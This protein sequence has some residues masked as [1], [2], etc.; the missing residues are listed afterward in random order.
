[1]ASMGYTPNQESC[2]SSKTTLA[3]VADPSN[4]QSQ[5]RL[6]TYSKQCTKFTRSVRR[7]FEHNILSDSSGS[8]LA[9]Y[10]R[11]H[12]QSVSPLKH[13]GQHSPATSDASKCMIM[14]RHY[15]SIFRPSVSPPIPQSYPLP[16]LTSPPAITTELISTYLELI[17][18]KRSSV[19]HVNGLLLRLIEGD[20][21]VPYL[22]DLIEKSFFDCFI[23]HQWK[24]SK[25]TPL[26]KGSGSRALPINYRP[27]ALNH[28]L[29]YLCEKIIFHC[30]INHL[31]SLSLLSNSQHG[32]R[33]RYSTLTNLLAALEQV[34]HARDI[35][36]SCAIVY[37]DFAKAFD[38]ISH[39]LRLDKLRRLR[40]GG[41][42]LKWIR[43]W[44]TGRKAFVQINN[45]SSDSFPVTSGV[46]QGSVLGPLLIIIY[47][48]DLLDYPLSSSL[49]QFC[50]DLKLVKL[51]SHTKD[52]SELQN[53]VDS[54]LSWCKRY[55]S[56]INISKCALMLFGSQSFS[57]NIGGGIIPQVSHI[58]DLGLRYDDKG[59][60]VVNSIMFYDQQRI[61][62]LNSKR[63]LF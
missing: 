28:P 53:D 31:E 5:A 27:I 8:S 6:I 63:G 54:V 45:S 17:P 18:R 44:L 1:M 32:A 62:S 55:D 11:P 41:C 3:Q 48:N 22:T 49:F 60:S 39:E 4:A 34:F 43:G 35:K 15:T 38:V 14:M 16:L 40:V 19:S 61:A 37:I 59:N 26:Y 30:L 13:D 21:L 29:S 33:S 46:P 58:R 50:D 25:L 24:V 51:I 36:M 10:I 52:I 7:S 23:P 2:A 42:V 12:Y 20:I 56:Q 57:L 47:V 9:S